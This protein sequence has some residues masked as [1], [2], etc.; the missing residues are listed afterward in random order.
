MVC[1]IKVVMEENSNWRL[2]ENRGTHNHGMADKRYRGKEKVHGMTSTNIWV[3]YS[4]DALFFS[5]MGKI[6]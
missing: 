4:I 1:E 2:N 6:I 3:A 5:H